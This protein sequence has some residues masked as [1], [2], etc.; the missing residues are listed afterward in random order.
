MK[1]AQ[2][3]LVAAVGKGD[4]IE[5][6]LLHELIEDI[7][8]KNDGPRDGDDNILE[9]VGEPVPFDQRI[10][11]G[12]SAGLSADRSFAD[13]GKL[14]V[15]IILFTVEIGNDTPCFVDPE[16]GDGIEDISLCLIHIA[17]T[18]RLIPR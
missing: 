6:V 18:R 13:P 2:D 3:L 4:L 11:K 15:F 12:Q 7:R 5:V 14:E 1:C 10:E 8:A 17:G 9:F 16:S